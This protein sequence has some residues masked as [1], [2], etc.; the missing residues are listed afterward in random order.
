MALAEGGPG[1]W[2]PGSYPV[3]YQLGGHIELVRPG[4]DDDR[5]AL[6]V[7]HLPAGPIKLPVPAEGGKQDADHA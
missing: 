7:K 5:P 2:A 1:D 4:N 6:P 3:P